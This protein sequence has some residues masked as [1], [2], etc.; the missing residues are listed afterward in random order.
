MGYKPKMKAAGG[1]G[2][3]GVAKVEVN[4]KDRNMIRFTLKARS[5]DKETQ[6]EKFEMLK[7]NVVR[8]DCPE[9]LQDMI[10]AGIWFISVNKDLDKIYGFRPVDGVFDVVVDRFSA[11]QD[12]PPTPKE[13]RGD[14]W[15]YL[16]FTAILRIVGGNEDGMKIPY[17]LRYHFDKELEPVDQAGTK[18]EVVAYSH[19]KSKYT[20]P[21]VDFMDAAGA[22]EKGP[23][24]YKD[25]ILPMLEKRIQEQKRTFKIVLRQGQVHSI[26]GG[27]QEFADEFTAS[28]EE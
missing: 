15:S 2:P 5:W 9:D 18:R 21:L 26:V 28:L 16:Y 25:N 22:W 27:T 4:P 20:A 1:F 17:T 8:S 6:T 13:F 23:M 3:Q 24:P 12:Q 7:G 19:P 10:R 14:K 11:Q